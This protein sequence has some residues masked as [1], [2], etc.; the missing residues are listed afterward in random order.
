M[1]ITYKH[2]L[3]GICA[4]LFVVAGSTVAEAHM[5]DTVTDDS[6]SIVTTEEFEAMEDVMLKMMNGEELTAAEAEA[7]SDFMESHHGASFPMMGSF[8][9]SW[10]MMS[11]YDSGFGMMGGGFLGWLFPLTM[12]V[13]LLVG[14][15]L[16]G[17]LIRKLTNQEKHE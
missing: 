14:L 7:M 1:R 16:I 2:V 15:L 12:L 5:G 3:V 8:N 10:N 13:W 11:G 9:G 4:V 6:D 17:V